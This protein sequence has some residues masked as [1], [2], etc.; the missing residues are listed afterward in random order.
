[1]ILYTVYDPTTGEVLRSGSAPSQDA[2]L[3]QGDDVL[4]GVA[5][6]DVTQYVLDG[7]LTTRPTLEEQ[8]GP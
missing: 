4:L 8:S 2:A 7:V 3:L 5:G 1:M 6:D